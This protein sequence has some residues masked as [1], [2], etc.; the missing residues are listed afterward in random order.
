MITLGTPQ[1]D[2]VSALSI[3]PDISDAVRAY[4]G[5]L[6]GRDI[7]TFWIY[8]AGLPVGQIALHDGDRAQ[9]EAL[10]AYHIFR[11]TDRGRGVGRQALAL[12]EEFARSETSLRTLVVITGRN[13]RA[14]R[15]IAEACDFV[16]AGGAWEDPERLVVYVW[17][18]PH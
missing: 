13:N 10:V 7:Q 16:E 14:S 1:P 11:A 17:M 12:L 9:G 5:P 6:D 15:R 8:E 4:L 2:I 3:D 18:I